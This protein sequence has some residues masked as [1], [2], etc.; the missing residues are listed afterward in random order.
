MVALACTLLA[1]LATPSWAQEAAKPVPISGDDVHAV[2]QQFDT[3]RLAIESAIVMAQDTKRKKSFPI[4]ITYPVITGKSPIIIFSHG[5]SQS[6]YDYGYLARYWAEH[7]YICVQPFHEDSLEW[8]KH[9]KATVDCLELITSMPRNKRAWVERAGD[10]SFIIDSLPQLF[11]KLANKFDMTRIG[12]GGHSYGGFTSLLLAGASVPRK[13]LPPQC[14]SVRDK[15]IKAIVSISSQGVRTGN[16]DTALAFDG[17]SSFTIAVP[18]LFVTGDRDQI[19]GTLVNQRTDAFQYSPPGDK[20]YVSLF[21]ANH[22][23]FV[24]PQHSSKG[25]SL[26]D[27]AI[28]QANN[29]L[30]LEPYGN[31]EAQRRLVQETSLIFWDAYLKGDAKDKTLLRQGALT[32]LVGKA[33]ETRLK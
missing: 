32:S 15:R 20:Y 27:L 26:I 8:A 28:E 25:N 2:V 17:K 11:P 24:V 22:M 3:D 30:M 7:G 16:G 13:D 12:M 14:N 33:G 31:Q 9:K 23:T 10:I 6:A 19:A 21:G 29:N 18:A 5:C 1:A 4:Y